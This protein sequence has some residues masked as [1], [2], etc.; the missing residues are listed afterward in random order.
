ME[1]A[2]VQPDTTIKVGDRV[3]SFD[4]D[5]R[6]LEGI[7]AAYVEGTVQKIEYHNGCDR[8]IIGVERRIFAGEV[9]VTHPEMI[10]APPVNG[11]PKM[12][13]GYTDGVVRV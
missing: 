4:F 9:S 13:G 2:E 11:T 1:T 6:D 7:R 12:F 10:V 8:Y 5:R 3:R